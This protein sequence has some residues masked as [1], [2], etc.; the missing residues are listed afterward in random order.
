MEG[1]VWIFNANGAHLPGAAFTSLD[2]A[3]SWIATHSLS[4]MLTVYPLDQGVYEWAVENG[5]FFP[6]K[7]ATP[8]FVGSF[9][10]AYQ[11]HHHYENGARIH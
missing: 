7:P 11:K 3:E 1:H 9:T 2:L 8:V 4:G 10:S 5:H 6:K